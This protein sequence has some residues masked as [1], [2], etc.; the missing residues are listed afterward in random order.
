MF[1]ATKNNPVTGDYDIHVAG[2]RSNVINFKKTM[3]DTININSDCTVQLMDADG[4]AG[5]NHAVHAAIHA[6]KSF[7]RK[8]NIS[9]DL[10]LEILVR[11]SGQRQISEAIQMLGIKNGEMNICAVTVGCESNIMGKLETIL[12]RRQDMVLEPDDLK[13]KD[14]YNISDIEEE[15]AGSVSKILIERTALLVLK[16]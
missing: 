8:E 14:K 7:A 2:F 13:L 1:G 3:S 5:K 16:K 15:S 9:N 12:G 4:I 6:I 10:G 11:A